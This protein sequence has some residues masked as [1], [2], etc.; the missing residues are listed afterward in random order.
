MISSME[1]AVSSGAGVEVPHAIAFL[2]GYQHHSPVQ[3][4]ANLR[5]EIP[6]VKDRRKFVTTE[7]HDYLL[8]TLNNQQ[9]GQL[10]R[11]IRQYQKEGTDDRIP[12]DPDGIVRDALAGIKA[13]IDSQGVRSTPCDW[14]VLRQQVLEFDNFTCQ[15][16][17]R[18]TGPLECD[19]M[20]PYSRGGADEFENLITA[21]KP[22]NRSKSRKTVS[23]W[24]VSNNGR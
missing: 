8:E 18:T 15:Y 23:E 3:L 9:L 10:W 21:C 17:G 12:F 16:C 14:A 4:F 1:K 22:C 2:C 13:E 11:A 7:E 20:M 5:Q 19:H 6:P 24:M